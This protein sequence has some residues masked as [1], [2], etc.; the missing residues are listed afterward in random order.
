VA[1]VVNDQT[2]SARQH[3]PRVDRTEVLASTHTVSV[4]LIRTLRPTGQ[5]EGKK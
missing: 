1:L 2:P 5:K 4:K 3:R